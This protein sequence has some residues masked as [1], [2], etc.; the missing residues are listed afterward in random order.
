MAAATTVIQVTA[1]DMAMGMDTD[2]DV[3]ATD[4]DAISRFDY[5]K[6]IKEAFS[7]DR[8]IPREGLRS[9]Q[10]RSGQIPLVFF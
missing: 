9:F 4:R 10:T 5:F 8:L 7:G 6:P 3:D 1:G 2:T